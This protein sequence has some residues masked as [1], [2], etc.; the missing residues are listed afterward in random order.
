MVTLMLLQGAEDKTFLMC[1]LLLS[2]ICKSWLSGSCPVCMSSMSP[3]AAASS[4]THINI[5]QSAAMIC[6]PRGQRSVPVEN[7]AEGWGGG[8]GKSES[9]RASA[10]TSC[11]LAFPFL[12]EL[13][14]ET[15]TVTWNKWMCM[16]CFHIIQILFIF[17]SLPTSSGG[18]GNYSF[19]YLFFSLNY[20]FF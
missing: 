2:P 18:A 11:T 8:G 1:I 5:S 20:Y 19:H 4:Y 9:E 16:R 6:S 17:I 13:T 3:A 14:H 15:D 10:G 12:M 7:K